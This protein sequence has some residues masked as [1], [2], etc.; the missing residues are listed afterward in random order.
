MLSFIRDE[1]GDDERQ[2]LY[3]DDINMYVHVA[4]SDTQKHS[5]AHRARKMETKK[6]TK[7]DYILNLL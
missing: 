2:N 4:H 1:R 3:V 6:W 5:L 7:G